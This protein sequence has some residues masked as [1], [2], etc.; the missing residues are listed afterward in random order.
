MNVAKALKVSLILIIEI[1]SSL[2]KIFTYMNIVMDRCDCRKYANKIKGYPS[3]K[4][5]KK[6]CENTLILDMEKH[7]GGHTFFEGD[8]NKEREKCSFAK[9]RPK[10]GKDNTKLIK[11]HPRGKK[12]ERKYVPNSKIIPNTMIQSQE[13]Q[14]PSTGTWGHVSYE[15][16]P[17][18]RANELKKSKK[19]YRNSVRYL[20][21]SRMDDVHVSDI[22]RVRLEN[23]HLCR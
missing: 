19:T 4:S 18:Y 5:K 7:F 11:K 13:A 6:E 23:R 9:E 22:M 3:V 14:E 1:H 2:L 10:G 17:I 15:L 20:K 21:P 8:F 16:F 12:F